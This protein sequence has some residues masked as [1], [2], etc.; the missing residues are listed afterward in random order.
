MNPAAKALPGF[1][2]A[3]GGAVSKN[4]SKQSS[5]R[6]V[7]AAIE[8]Q[9]GRRTGPKTPRGGL[10]PAVFGRDSGAGLVLRWTGLLMRS[11]GE[12]ENVRCQGR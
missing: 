1:R 8:R 2:T 3:R 9:F 7:L 4:E 5:L 6:S 11:R 12:K 10:R